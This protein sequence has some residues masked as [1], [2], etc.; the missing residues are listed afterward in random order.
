[1]AGELSSSRSQLKTLESDLK[2]FK[3]INK[4]YTDQLIKVKVLRL[5]LCFLQY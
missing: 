5:D 1:M 3:E 2:D 4:K